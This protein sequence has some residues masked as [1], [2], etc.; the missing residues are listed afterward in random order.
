MPFR[1]RARGSLENIW[2]EPCPIYAFQLT[3]A[4]APVPDDAAYLHAQF[5]LSRPLPAK[6]AH[7]V[8]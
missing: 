6:E 5:R 1:Q 2:D 8:E 4:L 3:Y 7:T